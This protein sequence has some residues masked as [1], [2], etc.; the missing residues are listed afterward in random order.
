[1]TD[2]EEEGRRQADSGRLEV[3]ISTPMLC[4]RLY[5]GARARYSGLL[6]L[7]GSRCPR[8][9]QLDFSASTIPRSAS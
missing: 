5:A 9:W 4:G 3:E 8:A 2:G 7:C 1:M 6:Q